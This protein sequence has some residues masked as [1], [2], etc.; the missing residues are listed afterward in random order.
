MLQE[1]KQLLHVLHLPIVVIL[2]IYVLRLS[3]TNARKNW[4]YLFRQA[5]VS[6]VIGLLTYKYL[7]DRDDLTEGFILVLVAFFA[8]LAD[9]IIQGISRV[10]YRMHY[11]PIGLAKDIR[12][13]FRG[14]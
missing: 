14:H 11:D 5:I 12:D 1:I 7:L 13:I 8:F 4:S 10:G 6:L 2:A 3:I 9:D